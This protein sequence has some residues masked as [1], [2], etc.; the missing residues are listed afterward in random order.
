MTYTAEQPLDFLTHF[1]DLP[2]PR[3]RGKVLYP[4][5]ELLLCC[6]VGVLC[7]ANGWVEVEEYSQAKLVFLRRLLPFEDGVAS[8]DTFP[9]TWGHFRLS[10]QHQLDTRS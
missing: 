7:G 5:P 4:L 9:F 8:H 10:V 3:Q 6:L 1:D 2:D